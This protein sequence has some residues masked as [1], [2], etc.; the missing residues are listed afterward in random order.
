MPGPDQNF[1]PTAISLL[2]YI[3]PAVGSITANGQSVTISGLTLQSVV[4]V[5]L[6]GT[7]TIDLAPEVSHDGT[8]FRS[9]RGISASAN[10]TVTSFTTGTGS[11]GH[12]SIW[13]FPIN[14]AQAFR[15]RSTAFTS[16]TVNITLAPQPFGLPVLPMESPQNLEST[17][18]NPPTIPVS[19]FN[20]LSTAS[21][22]AYQR[23]VTANTAHDT[24]GTGVP[25]N[26]LIAVVEDSADSAPANRVS[27]EGDSVK[28]VAN[29]DG[30]LYMLPHSPQ[31]WDYKLQT[32]TQQT[33]TV[34]HAAPGANLAIYITDIYCSAGGAVTITL[35]D[36]DNNHVWAYPAAASGD[37]AKDS[38]L[39][40]IRVTTN[41]ALEID[42]SGAVQVYVN[43][44]GYIAP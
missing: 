38:R 11:T 28:A 13:F 29:R 41:K 17:G 44:S 16:G 9:V 39:C 43:V 2:Q 10:A 25:A 32:G 22:A 12:N 14:G 8:N 7:W 35:Q 15:I 26:G 36:E 20:L 27:T 34:V 4:A 42:T 6:T 30:A 40:P 23:Q 5:Q 37:G 1:E 31:I 24:T 21:A 18:G 19:G 3:P 33:D